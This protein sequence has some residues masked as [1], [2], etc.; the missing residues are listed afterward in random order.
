[1]GFFRSLSVN[2]SFI[3]LNSLYSFD[4]LSF[5]TVMFIIIALCIGM[6]LHAI[7][8]RSYHVK[9]ISKLPKYILIP[10]WFV[11]IIVGLLL[12]QGQSAKFIYFDF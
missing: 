6:F 3:F 2:D 5:E 12:S 8:L 10:I 4:W 9:I 7:D 11:V 1:M